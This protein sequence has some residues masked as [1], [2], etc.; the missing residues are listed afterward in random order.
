MASWLEVKKLQKPTKALLIVPLDI[1]ASYSFPKP[2]DS[3]I[4]IF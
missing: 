4:Q 3:K 2:F 1:S